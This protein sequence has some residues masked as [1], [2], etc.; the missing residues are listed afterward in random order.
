M[1][2]TP[3]RNKCPWRRLVA[4]ML[5][6]MMILLLNS[7]LVVFTLGATATATAATTTMTTTTATTVA[8]TTATNPIVDDDPTM[9]DDNPAI[10][11]DCQA[12]PCNRTPYIRH[13]WYAHATLMSVSFM[14]LIP[15]A[16]M[17]SLIRNLLPAV[18]LGYKLHLIL[19]GT[20]LILIVCGF[21]IAVYIKQVTR[22]LP[23]FAMS[24]NHRAI[25]LAIVLLLVVHSTLAYFRPVVAAAS[26][27]NS[28]TT[29]SCSQQQCCGGNHLHLKQEQGTEDESSNEQKNG[30]GDDL[31]LEETAAGQQHL[32]PHQTMSTWS[33]DSCRNSDRNNNNNNLEF[34]LVRFVWETCHRFFGF[35][36]LMLGWYNCVDGFREYQSDYDGEV[37]L[38]HGPTVYLAWQGIVGAMILLLLSAKASK[39]KV[40]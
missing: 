6:W 30:G 9:V 37:L 20:A 28:I 40:L 4:S 31:I 19:N 21:C 32:R 24:C 1:I 3:R 16:I 15:S 14:I 36:I 17:A 29:T 23:H 22:S 8:V 27:S 18:N 38:V 12:G 33:S 39:M 34:S 10:G 2:L 25:G 5:W 26:S 7:S 13:L 35:V 11:N